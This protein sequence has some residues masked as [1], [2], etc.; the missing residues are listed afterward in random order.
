MTVLSP[1]RSRGLA[2]AGL[3]LLVPIVVMMVQG[4]LTIEAAAWRAALL[5]V[6]LAV[7]EHIVLPVARLIVG[8]G[9]AADRAK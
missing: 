5:L 3:L 7:V 2:I 4:S 6:A 9:H 1:I 8:D